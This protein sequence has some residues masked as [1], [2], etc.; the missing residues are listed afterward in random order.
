VRRNLRRTV[1]LI[2][3]FLI[4]KTETFRG[5]SGTT[6]LRK[7]YSR[8][9]CIGRR[10]NVGPM[11]CAN[12]LKLIPQFDRGAF[13]T[14]KKK[15][16]HHPAS[17]KEGLLVLALTEHATAPPARTMVWRRRRPFFFFAALPWCTHPLWDDST[18]D[19]GSCPPY[20]KALSSLCGPPVVSIGPPAKEDA[21]KKIDTT[22]TRE[23]DTRERE[24]KT[25]RDE[26]RT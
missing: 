3:I 24:R 15:L 26:T 10:E 6:A 2:F 11:A 16:A 21:P 8:S 4:S 20:Q 22:T 18:C 5:S 25:T 19:M 17:H 1:I 9:A 13:G 23:L 12:E 7:A 14:R